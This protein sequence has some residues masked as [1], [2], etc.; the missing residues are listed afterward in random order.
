[1]NNNEAEELLVKLEAVQ[2]IVIASAYDGSPLPEDRTSCSTVVL[3]SY[4]H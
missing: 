1:M 2:D 4:R 3:A